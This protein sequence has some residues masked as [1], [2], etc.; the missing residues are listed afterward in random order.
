MAKYL[1]TIISSKIDIA[2][3]IHNKMNYTFTK[4]VAKWGIITS[5]AL[6]LSFIESLIPF[7]FGI[8][9]MKL[10]L[11]NIIVVILLDIAS[12]LQHYL[13]PGRSVSFVCGYADPVQKQA[14]LP[15]R[16]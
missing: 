11:C 13:Q 9:G 3:D 4:R 8:P 5:L 16:Y 15:Y 10:G 1:L 6:I 14:F 2:C 7:F 12:W